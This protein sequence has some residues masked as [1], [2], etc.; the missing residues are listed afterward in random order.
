MGKGS[1]AGRLSRAAR[2]LWRA[3]GST[4]L[5]A[6]LL[7]A[8]L[9]ATLLASLFPQM[10]AS[11]AA[12]DPW[13]AA[14][15]L[16]YRAATSLL[17]SL[18]LFQVYLSAWYR[19]LLAFL[20]LNLLACTLQRLP[21]L[22]RSLARTPDVRHAEAFYEGFSR[23]SQCPASSLANGLLAAQSILARHRYHSRVERDEKGTRA[24]LYAE[25]HRWA[26]AGTLLSHIAA[27]VLALAVLARPVLGW[28]ESGIVLAPGQVYEIGHG[29]A[30]AVRA[31]DL[32]IDFHPGGEPRDYRAPLAV[33]EDGEALVRTVGINRPLTHQ[34]VAFHLQ[35]YGPAARLATPQGEVDLAFT[36]S[37]DRATT[38]P[39]TDLTLQVAY[40]P[41]DEAL[42]V[43][44]FAGDGSFAGSGQVVDGQEIEIQGTPVTFHLGHYTVWQVSHDP[45]VSLAAGAGLLMLAGIAVSL[46]LPRRRLWLRADRQGLRMVGAGDFGAGFEALGAA[47]ARA[48]EAEE[49]GRAQE[50]GQAQ[51]AGQAQGAAGEPEEQAGD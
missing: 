43:V 33:L 4:R 17:H 35:S 8:L 51:E 1:Q 40:L 18:G 2:R 11:P 7:A 19:T 47:L 30:F 27:L 45:T 36:G 50:V 23:R 12:R 32:E 29:H 14:V 15:S 20:L 22:W 3:L 16:R 21:R 39:G 9:L 25:Q 10:P 34:G 41:Q 38:L 6:I 44:A 49:A 13:L 24:C 42:F 28:Q 26:Q 48:C 31:G 37:Q 5:A 46:W